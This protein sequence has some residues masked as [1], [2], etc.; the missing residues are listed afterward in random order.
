MVHM[1]RGLG[2]RA[3][4][5]YASAVRSMSSKAYIVPLDPSNPSKNAALNVDPSALWAKLPP[6]KKPAKAGTSHL[7]YGLGAG[8]DVAALVSLGEA[9]ET[10]KGDARRE[11]IRKA[12]GSGV[13]GIKGLGE[14]VSEAVID[15]S[16]DPQAAGEVLNVAYVAPISC[17]T[18][19]ASH[20][21]LYDFTL[22]TKPPS[23]FDPRKT[24]PAPE[25]PKL[26][27][28]AETDDW[29]RGVVY[30]NAQNFARTVS[31]VP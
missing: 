6:S 20:L 2:F 23:A 5:R 4:Q 1:L 3:G 15:T 24:E 28:T 30:A 17:Q 18:A 21:A 10:K 31:S 14:G 19:V 8:K 7:F 27:P 29:N 12:V 25:K 22:K 11:I 16:T 9:F 26:V 13:K